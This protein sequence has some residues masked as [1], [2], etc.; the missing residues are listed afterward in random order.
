[1]DHHCLFMYGCVARNN[2]RLFVI[3]IIFTCLLMFTFSYFAY[4][5][6]SLLHPD[7]AFFSDVM[8]AS[9]SSHPATFFLML[10]NAGSAMWLLT[11]LR[12]QLS[13]ISRNMT[14]VW[15]PYRGASHLSLKQRCVNVINFLR[16]K[17]MYSEPTSTYTA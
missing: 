17:A 2:H 7:L 11:L 13:V 10:G 1:M 8:L 12:F 6:L 3:F 5:Y 15:Q 4:A 9:W 16:G 14:T